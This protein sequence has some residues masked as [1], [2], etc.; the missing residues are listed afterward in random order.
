M[1]LFAS[2]IERVALTGQTGGKYEKCCDHMKEHQDFGSP[3]AILL[4][5]LQQLIIYFLTSTKI[6]N[7]R[8]PNAA[9]F[10]PGLG[11]DEKLDV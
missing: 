4:L 9:L 10:Q 2:L 1:L 11:P 6:M 3:I 8:L 5:H 7:T